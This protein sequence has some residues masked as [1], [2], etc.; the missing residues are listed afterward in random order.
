M[1]I[2]L[3]KPIFHENNHLHMEY[4]RVLVRFHLVNISLLIIQKRFKNCII[5]QDANH[6]TRKNDTFGLT[7]SSNSA[8]QAY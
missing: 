3:E 5:F 6:G 1:G 4:L 2:L 8:K 7:T